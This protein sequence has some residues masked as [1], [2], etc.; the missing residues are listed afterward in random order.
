MSA[1][2]QQGG[3][4]VTALASHPIKG[5]GTPSSAVLSGT[6]FTTSDV[7]VFTIAPDPNTPDGFIITSVTPG[8]AVISGTVVATELDGRVHTIP[9][10]PD[11][12]TVT[13]TPPP[14][15]PPAVAAGVTFGTPQPPA[16]TSK[17]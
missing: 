16:V 10:T 4:T 7:N 5:D 1:S 12:V 14:P 2:L 15:E 6:S 17:V 8:S 11:T 9:I 3:F 13:E